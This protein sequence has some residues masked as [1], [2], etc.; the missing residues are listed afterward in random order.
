MRIYEKYVKSADTVAIVTAILAAARLMN[1][2]AKMDR[3][4]TPRE[5]ELIIRSS[6]GDACTIISWVEEL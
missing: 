6:L 3:E 2:H 4:A 1:H 5:R